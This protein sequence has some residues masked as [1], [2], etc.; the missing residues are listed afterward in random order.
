MRTRKSGNNLQLSW[1]PPWAIPRC[2]QLWLWV[3][4]KIK[5]KYFTTKENKSQINSKKLRP[6]NSKPIL[7]GDLMESNISC[8]QAIIGRPPPQPAKTF[9]TNPWESCHFQ[10]SFSLNIDHGSSRDQ[11]FGRFLGWPSM[12]AFIKTKKTQFKL[13]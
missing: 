5:K 6:V 1:P 11:K 13:K 4:L 12:A 3:N 10:A 2:S 8:P 7:C 9:M